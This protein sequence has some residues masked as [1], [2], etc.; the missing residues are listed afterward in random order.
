MTD[1]SE[2]PAL[3]ARMRALR[4][5]IPAKAR[6]KAAQ[7]LSELPLSG[8]GFVPGCTVSGF[9]A[10]G[11]EIDPAPLIQRI[12][13]RSLHLCLPVMQGKDRP[14][15][16]RTYRPGDELKTVQWG[17]RQPRDDQPIVVPDVLLVPLLAVDPQGYRLGYGGG[18]YDRTIKQLRSTK[19]IVTIGLAFDLQM[20]DAV[21]HLDY[22]EPLDWVLTP[23]G[24]VRCR[25]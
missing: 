14:L 6:T 21:P 15:L 17:I 24:P 9:L 1:D 12:G 22:D 23:S 13:S 25:R 2:K 5:A 16:F 10:I 8:V 20:I 19:R 3:R 11:D 4:A 7:K 18:Y